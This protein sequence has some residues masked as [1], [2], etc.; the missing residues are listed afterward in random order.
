MKQKVDEKTKGQYSSDQFGYIRKPMRHLS[1]ISDVQKPRS[2]KVK[3]RNQL[4]KHSANWWWFQRFF[5]SIL[6]QTLGKWSVLTV[7]PA[8]RV[9]V[10][11]SGNLFFFWS[12]DHRCR[13]ALENARML[14]VSLLNHSKL[15]RR[16]GNYMNKLK[17]I[18]ICLTNMENSTSRYLK[19]M[20]G[21]Y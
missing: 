6:A 19:G 1:N 13:F 11:A 2:F 17:A 3:K 21:Q 4:V 12:S 5:K 8:T 20:L 14:E 9:G 15:G 10:M 18:Q 16:Y 7:A